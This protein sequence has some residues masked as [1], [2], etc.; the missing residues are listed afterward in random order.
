LN[1]ISLG[2]IYYHGKYSSDFHGLNF[3]MQNIRKRVLLAL[4]ISSQ[5]FRLG[6]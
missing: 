1:D 3:R 6:V 2:E 5:D 4:T